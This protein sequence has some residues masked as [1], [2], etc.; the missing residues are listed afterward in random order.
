MGCGR[1]LPDG[2]FELPVSVN[3]S[4]SPS[5][6]AEWR[7]AFEKAAQQ[8]YHA[9]K[10]QLRLGRFLVANNRY[11][12]N[13]AEAVL[14][15]TGDA[16]FAN[17]LGGFG[18]APLVFQVHLMPSCK[19]NPMVIV[20]ELAH[21]ILAL[22]DEYTG[23]PFSDDIVADP[24]VVAFNLIPIDNPERDNNALVGVSAMLKRGTLV[25]RREVTASTAN[26]VTVSG[27]YSFLATQADGM[28]VWYQ[29]PRQICLESGDDDDGFVCLMQESS[30]AGQYL[31]TGVYQ[32]Y[33]GPMPSTDFCSA[34]NHDPDGDTSHSVLYDGRSCW[35]VISEVMDSR[36][37]FPLTV[38]DPPTTSPPPG[39]SDALLPEWVALAEEQRIVL[40]F[41]RSGSMA[42]SGKVDHARVAAQWWIDQARADAE[43]GGNVLRVGIVPFNQMV[44][45]ASVIPLSAPGDLPT[46]TN[47][48]IDQI[49][50]GGWTNIRDALLRGCLEISETPSAPGRAATQAVVLLTDGL[51]NTPAGTSMLDAVDALA[52]AGC[53]VFA[54][55][56]GANEN[57]TD[58]A[59]LEELC[60][61]THGLF[62]F[63]AA[64][65]VAA[66]AII[67]AIY[68]HVL[69]GIV[70]FGSQELPASLAS[71]SDTRF[72][73]ISAAKRP[74]LDDVFAA[75]SISGMEDLR[76]RVVRR[77]RRSPERRDADGRFAVATAWIE[78]GAERASFSVTAPFGHA[79]WLY[80]IDPDGHPVD[81]DAPDVRDV[82]GNGNMAFTMLKNPKPGLW[83]MV[84][85]RPRAGEAI[86]VHTVAGVTHRSIAV[87]ATASP[88]ALPGGAV[89]LR[90]TVH[91]DGP[92]SGLRV[93]ASLTGPNGTRHDV[94]LSDATA[95]DA[96]SGV[97]EGGFS[98]LM[99]GRYDVWFH[100]AGDAR[101][102]PAAL[103]N[104]LNHLPA[105]GRKPASGLS[106][107]LTASR[108]RR[109][110]PASFWVGE[111]PLLIDADRIGRP[112][113]S[114][115]R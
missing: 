16:S 48:R 1:F 40:L 76:Q 47:E 15:Q 26:L 78:K 36:F 102:V 4:A 46:D 29:D 24:N 55:G 109:V 97:Y 19:V 113:I 71:P 73:K 23:P 8:F 96:A 10:G 83:T 52:E 90:A 82:P 60:R 53:R 99:P 37:N 111:R 6:L 84:L 34:S 81:L 28:R 39:W 14:Y 3:Y 94:L 67:Q 17:I 2:R 59:G 31:S 74:H 12:L 88:A 25:E 57:E 51:H 91:W 45:D 89:H 105:K 7:R 93:R 41:D 95:D 86:T 18:L 85:F 22:G 50:A 9:T 114:E 56:F 68:T 44:A 13:E 80:V 62:P 64:N 43:L 70:A 115:R 110:V 32:D 54:V 77:E 75:L 87:A 63:R 108:F 72:A 65:P 38:P 49:V 35:Q 100:I 92:L 66:Q 27:S 106:V 79:V 21:H 61:Q 101:M 20:H 5:D 11:G 58:M 104:R 33:V 98:P 103:P 107:P 42:E 112:P 30:N 69:G